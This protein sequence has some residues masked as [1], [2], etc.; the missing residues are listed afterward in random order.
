MKE[1][2]PLARFLQATLAPLLRALFR[3][4]VLG[5]ENLPAEGPAILAGNHVSYA[6][7]ILLWCAAA[8]RP[9]HFMAKAELWG[10]PALGWLM[11]RL[12]MF[13]VRRD[14]ADRNAIA[15]AAKHLEAGE[16]VGM[17]P[18]G[19]RIRDA[20]AESSA[21]GGVA[22]LALRARVPVVPVGI[23]GTDRIRP[24]GMRLMRFPRVTYR[25]GPPIRP[26]DMPGEGRRGRVDAFTAE[27]MRRIGEARAEAGEA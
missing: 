2:F 11:D 14:V 12:R 24:E 10:N 22:F 7:P 15:M 8:P 21:H 23:A 3:M 27:L 18:E 16:L 6:D 20:A 19:T 4:R 25:F 9:V 26:E 1:H 13:P 17:F 5:R